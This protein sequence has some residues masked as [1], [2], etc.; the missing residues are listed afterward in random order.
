MDLAHIWPTENE[1]VMLPGARVI[2][3]GEAG[4]SIR[5]GGFNLGDGSRTVPIAA[6]SIIYLF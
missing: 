3:R 5:D 6:A 4:V 2:L 1:D